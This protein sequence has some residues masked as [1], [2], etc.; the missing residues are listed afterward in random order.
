MRGIFIAFLL[1]VCSAVTG[2]H[3]EPALP[4]DP[5]AFWVAVTADT[6]GAA[7]CV[8]GTPGAAFTVTGW[9]WAPP[10]RGLAYVTYRF[11]FPAAL[12]H[13]ARPRAHPL[14]AELIV[15]EYHD[16]T[17]EWNFVFSSCQA[18]WIPVYRQ[19]CAL[20]GDQPGRVTILARHSMIRDCD[21][22]LNDVTTLTEIE[23]NDPGCATVGD[24][25]VSWG[26]VKARFAPPARSRGP[27][28]GA[29][30]AGGR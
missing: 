3:A 21:W 11:A 22:V 5:G 4:P 17:S 29:P 10:D 7:D 6:V 25:A 20:A 8:S 18:G 27:D 26:E 14:V 1:V 2:A 24:A 16:G 28:A 15:T 30:R 12:D 13:R 9:A 23:L 19:T